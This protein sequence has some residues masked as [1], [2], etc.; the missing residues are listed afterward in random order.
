[1]A[2]GVT[3]GL[4]ASATALAQAWEPTKP[5][6]FVVPAGQG[7][8]ADQMARFIQSVVAKNR[9]SPQPINVIN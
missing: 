5:I 2:L 3:A 4:L 1:M 6:D 7:G 8:G 9:L